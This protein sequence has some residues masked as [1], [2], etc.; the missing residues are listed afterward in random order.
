[1][2]SLKRSLFL[3]SGKDECDLNIRLKK[4]TEGGNDSV[5]VE[6]RIIKINKGKMNKDSQLV[7]TEES[8]AKK[9]TG[10]SINKHVAE[11]QLVEVPISMNPSFEL[12]K[13]DVEISAGCGGWPKAATKEI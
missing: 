2:L 9:E 13:D 5:E 1:M 10:E 3:L 7:K 6:N 11:A 4:K 12:R 8:S